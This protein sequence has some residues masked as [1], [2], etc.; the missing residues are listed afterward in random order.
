MPKDTKILRVFKNKTAIFVDFPQR[1]IPF[2]R[3]ENGIWKYLD[4][5]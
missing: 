1:K 2:P 4:F 3:Q 5:M